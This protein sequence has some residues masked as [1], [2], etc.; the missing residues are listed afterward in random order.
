MTR[1]LFQNGDVVFVAVI[2]F[3]PIAASPFNRVKGTYISIS[4]S[5]SISI[6]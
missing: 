3:F 4:T 1:V 2:L 6:P 5:F